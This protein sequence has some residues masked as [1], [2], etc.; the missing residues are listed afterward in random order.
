MAACV[1]FNDPATGYDWAPTDSANLYGG[2]GMCVCSRMR[3]VFAIYT[4]IIF[5]PG[6]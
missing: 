6:W 2:G 1:Y 4:I 3:D 5:D